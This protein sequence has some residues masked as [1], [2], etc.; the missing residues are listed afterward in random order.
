MVSISKTTVVTF[1]QIL[2][3]KLKPKWMESILLNEVK[4][5]IRFQKLVSKKDFLE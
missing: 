3:I 5:G 2:H 1:K 4:E